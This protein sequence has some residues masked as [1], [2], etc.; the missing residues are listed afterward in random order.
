MS[1]KLQKRKEQ[2]NRKIPLIVIKEI[3]SEND[4]TQNDDEIK[5]YLDCL[6]ESDFRRY[7][8]SSVEE[9]E[10]KSFYERIRKILTR[11]EKYI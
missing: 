11:L 7:S 4:N 3:L 8:G 6:Q 5:E 2:T 9:G 10:L 1:T